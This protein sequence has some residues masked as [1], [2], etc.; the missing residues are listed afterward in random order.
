M[1]RLLKTYR[2]SIVGML[3][4]S[5]IFAW[6]ATAQTHSPYLRVFSSMWDKVIRS[7]HDTGGEKVL[8][9]G[10]PQE[11]LMQVLPAVLP[12]SLWNPKMT[13][14]FLLIPNLIIFLALFP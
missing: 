14:L 13:Y 1:N 6:H 9:D 12:F 10:G 3:A 11:N 4:L 8:I 5:T 7:F 2:Y